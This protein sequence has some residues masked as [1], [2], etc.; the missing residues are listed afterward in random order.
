MHE[1]KKRLHIQMRTTLSRKDRIDYLTTLSSHAKVTHS[2]IE[3]NH[4]F[5][6]FCYIFAL[7]FKRH[8]PVEYSLFYASFT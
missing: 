5:L 1:R 2:I 4:G 3:G 6:D 7:P 8:L